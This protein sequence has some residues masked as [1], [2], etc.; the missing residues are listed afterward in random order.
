MYICMTVREVK[1]MFIYK[2]LGKVKVMYIHNSAMRK[3]KVV[4]ICKHV[5]LEEK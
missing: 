3:V 4:S 1:V 5:D 2:S